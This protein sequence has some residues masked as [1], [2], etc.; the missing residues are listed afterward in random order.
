MSAC[1]AFLIPLDRSIHFVFRVFDDVHVPTLISLFDVRASTSHKN[2]IVLTSWENKSHKRD[3]RS[4]RGFMSH[5]EA[6]SL[7]FYHS[8]CCIVHAKCVQNLGNSMV[9]YA[10]RISYWTIGINMC[11]ESIFT[12]PLGYHSKENVSLFLTIIFCSISNH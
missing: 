2:R 9:P 11:N 1:F 3:F 6:L 12:S 10:N 5:I 4:D 7:S 8:F